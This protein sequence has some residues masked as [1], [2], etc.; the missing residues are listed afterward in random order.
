MIKESQESVYAF[1]ALDIS[2]SRNAVKMCNDCD[3][4]LK[5]LIG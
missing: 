2:D 5:N 3:F 4:G 1:N